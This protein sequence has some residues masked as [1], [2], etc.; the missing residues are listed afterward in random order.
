MGGAISTKIVSL[1]RSGEA[2]AARQGP[3]DVV[4]CA[5][6]I[7]F[8]NAAGQ[9]FDSELSTIQHSIGGHTP[10]L[11]SKLHCLGEPYIDSSQRLPLG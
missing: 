8:L 10:Q 2:L 7:Q 5:E 11:I 6:L 3:S 1:R 4:L 9:N